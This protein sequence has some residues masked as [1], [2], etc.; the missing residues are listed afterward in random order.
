MNLPNGE[1]LLLTID[2][3]VERE[4]GTCRNGKRLGYDNI[5]D[6]PLCRGTGVRKVRVRGAVQMWPLGERVKIPAWL[7]TG[8]NV[9]RTRKF[10]SANEARDAIIAAWK[11]GTL[12]DALAA[13]ITEED[14]DDEV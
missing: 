2:R 1:R 12:P 8:I 10:D 13:T 9:G 3:V 14:C 4:C 11:D 7:G 6:C 5:V